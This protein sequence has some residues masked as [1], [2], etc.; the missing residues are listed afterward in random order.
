[1]IV[2]SSYWRLEQ[3]MTVSSWQ[4]LLRL[5]LVA[6]VQ[7]NSVWRPTNVYWRVWRGWYIFS[8]HNITAY[9][10]RDSQTSVH[11]NTNTLTSSAGGRTL[12]FEGRLRLSPS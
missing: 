8:R 3:R 7:V 11:S 12:L 1:M 10:A 6:V 2:S 5:S 4:V 9:L